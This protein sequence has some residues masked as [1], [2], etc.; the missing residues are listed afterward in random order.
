MTG[1]LSGA[2]GKRS[3]GP[4]G[5]SA[6]EPGVHGPPPLQRAAHRLPDAQSLPSAPGA[7]TRPPG[8]PAAG[9]EGVAANVLNE[10]G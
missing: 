1:L 10:N 8:R 7:A 4:V 9:G 6:G 5:P 2:F 3:D